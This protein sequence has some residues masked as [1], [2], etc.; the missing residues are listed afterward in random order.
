MIHWKA[1]ILGEQTVVKKT[2]LFER[3]IGYWIGREY[4]GRGLATTETR[5]KSSS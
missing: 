2:I 5:S 3:E 4:W 1:K